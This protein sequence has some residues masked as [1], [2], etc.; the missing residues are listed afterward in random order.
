MSPMDSFLNLTRTDQ[1]VGLSDFENFSS[2]IYFA[3][4]RA[5]KPKLFYTILFQSI[6]FG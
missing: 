5:N 2:Q 1:L 4:A 3:K 6:E